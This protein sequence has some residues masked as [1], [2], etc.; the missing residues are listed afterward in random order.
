MDMTCCQR[1]LML[2]ALRRPVFM[3][4]IVPQSGVIDDGP[5]VMIVP[6]VRIVIGSVDGGMR[7]DGSRS[8]PLARRAQARGTVLAKDSDSR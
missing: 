1:I 3:A 8:H 7:P 4:S 2:E 6:T 5:R